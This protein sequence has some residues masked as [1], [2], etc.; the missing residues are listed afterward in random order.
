[1]ID[2]SEQES[3]DK[4][5]HLSNLSW[6]NDEL[7]NYFRNTVIPQLFVDADFILRKF[8]PPAMK[9]FNLS[10]ADVGRHISDVSHNIRYPTI[11]ENITE[12]IESKQDL[13]KEIQT[14]D[15]RW[16]QMNVLPYIVQKE[17]KSNGVI[18]TFVDITDRIEILKRYERLNLNYENIF[19][20]VSHDLK[21]PLAN[22]EGL[23]KL[24]EEVPNIKKGAE[25]AK[26]II[27][28]LNLSVGNLRKTIEELTTEVY[29][30]DEDS[31]FAEAEE[32]ISL[33]KIVEDVQLALKD[34]ISRTDARTTTEFNVSEIKFSKKNIRST[35]YNLVSN[36]IKYKA[37]DR[38]PEILIKT[39]K[40]NDYV[41]LSVK[42]NGRGIEE[43]KQEVIFS[44]YTRLT[45]DDDVEGT[46]VGL[47][48]VKRMVESGGGKIEVESSLGKGSTFK[49]YLK[50]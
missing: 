44:R 36:A 21:G 31:L 3:E 27:K 20:S 42:D 23:I 24:L 46:G 14:T 37:P 2:P 50:D 43:D 34:K 11:V 33:E 4:D 49:V 45:D 1:M 41:L 5:K 29:I 12:V 13:E 39:E 8:T 22:I 19:Y 40:V 48:I 47:F 15:L 7:E 6:L 16:Y 38:V 30:G 9:H 28:V 35:I 10:S 17:N 25:D 26:S 18:I 32:R